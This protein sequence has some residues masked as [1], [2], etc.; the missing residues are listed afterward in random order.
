MDIK[1]IFYCQRQLEAITQRGAAILA[2]T[3]KL[4]TG[5]LL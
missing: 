4:T 1:V 2:D 3:V 5:L